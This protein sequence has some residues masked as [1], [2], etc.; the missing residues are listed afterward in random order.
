MFQIEKRVE[1]Q[2]TVAIFSYFDT[3]FPRLSTFRASIL[4]H[5]S[6]PVVLVETMELKKGEE[7]EWILEEK[8]HLLLRRCKKKKIR[9]IAV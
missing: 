9:K 4:N 6:I 1:V 7:L 5:I 2:L 8:S 3:K